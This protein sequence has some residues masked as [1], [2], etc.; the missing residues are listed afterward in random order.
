MLTSQA[1][2]RDLVELATLTER[3]LS[4]GRRIAVTSVRGGAG[5]STVTALL[6]SAYARRRPDPILAAD[7]DPDNGSLLWRL[8]MVNFPPLTTLA[9]RLQAARHSN[10]QALEQILPRTETGLWMLPGGAA[11][12][13]QL[14][15]DVT[16]ALSRWFAI[17]VTDCGPSSSPCTVELMSEAHAVVVVAPA[18]PDGVRSTQRVLRQVP[19]GPDSLRSRVVVA[20]N[21]LSTHGVNALRTRRAHDMFRALEVPVVTLPYDRHLAG[22]APILMSHIAEATLVETTR[23]AAQALTQARPL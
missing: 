16:R 23:L 5:K 17:C 22:G 4:T 14:A 10:L 7:G 2:T 13:P 8:G 15:K 9:P 3:S 1:V 21:T 19:A 11:G 20:L 6:A 18:T 12:Q